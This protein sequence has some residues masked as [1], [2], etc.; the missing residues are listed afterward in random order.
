MGIANSIYFKIWYSD[1]MI[2]VGSLLIYGVFINLR[3]LAI[4]PEAYETEYGFFYGVAVWANGR[5]FET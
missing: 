4:A 2:T 1:I 3:Q 5:S